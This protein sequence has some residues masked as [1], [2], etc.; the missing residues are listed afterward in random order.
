MAGKIIR[1][2]Q[3]F[4]RTPNRPYTITE[5][6]DDPNNRDADG[7]PILKKTRNR[8][9]L[10]TFVEAVEHAHLLVD[11]DGKVLFQPGDFMKLALIEQQAHQANE[12]LTVTLEEYRLLQ[13]VADHGLMVRLEKDGMIF[14]F[15]QNARIPALFAIV[16]ET[17]ESQPQSAGTCRSD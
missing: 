5:E 1:H 10:D 13:K 9:W 4:F 12:S 2:R 16:V 15:P 3:E 8:T 11:K 17:A 7:K 14:P 6:V